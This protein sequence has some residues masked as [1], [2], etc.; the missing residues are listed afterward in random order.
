M[1]TVDSPEALRKR[2]SDGW[3]SVAS[4]SAKILEN[5]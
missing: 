3:E 4:G 2:A 1:A 5:K